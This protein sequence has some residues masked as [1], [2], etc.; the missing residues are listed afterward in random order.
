FE[1]KRELEAYAR[2][3]G[4]P[5]ESLD[6]AYL[7]GLRGLPP[8]I[9]THAEVVPRRPVEPAELQ[10]LLFAQFFL[11]QAKGFLMPPWLG[12]AVCQVVGAGGNRGLLGRLN[13]KVRALLTRAGSAG[14]DWLFRTRGLR[15]GALLRGWR[16]LETFT[17][18]LRL[19]T[20]SRSLGEFLGG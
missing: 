9:A 5:L 19:F 6:G 3:L 1:G 2:R 20:Y 7:H 10:R 11:Q 4:L 15:L 16:D 17:A 8:R 12:I 13:R 14:A 18:L